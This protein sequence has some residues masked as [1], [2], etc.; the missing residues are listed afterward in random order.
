MKFFKMIIVGLLVISLLIN[1]R[2][3]LR[4]SDFENQVNSIY[5]SQNDIRSTVE[6]QASN[7][8]GI[9]E[10]FK[11][12]QSWISPVRME[13]GNKNLG[14]GQM[15]LNFNWQIRELVTNSEVVFH[16]KL[17]E[18]PKYS[19]APAVEIGKG[20]FEVSIP[21]DFQLE[22]EWYTAVSV[23]SSTN[24]EA[25]AID[26]GYMRDYNKSEISYY[27]TVSKNDLVKS[28]E[29]ITDNIGYLGN[30]Y[31]GSLETFVDIYDEGFH[32]SVLTMPSNGKVF[33]KDAYLNKYKNG[34]L[35]EEEKLDFSEADHDS[36]WDIEE[37][38]FHYHKN[39]PN[40]PNEKF[41]YTSLVLKV[42]YS[43]GNSFEREI[44]SD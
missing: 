15:Q 2:L 31:Y 24:M 30:H 17:G 5:Y 38:G 13:V 11:R 27:V 21:F 37:H 16:Y 14:S 34:Q 25:D 43:D 1:A 26:E 22:P 40:L 32:L 35:I 10:E 23:G 41:E 44:F 39:F 36:N 6:D 29:I 19:S 28:G 3:L 7:F 18:D 33:L 8:Y 42:I 9:L 20:L 12:E 4:F